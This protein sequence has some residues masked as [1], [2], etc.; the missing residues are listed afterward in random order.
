[1]VYSYSYLMFNRK[2]FASMLFIALLEHTDKMVRCVCTVQY[3]NIKKI[4]SKQRLTT[5]NF[6][7][8]FNLFY[9]STLKTLLTIKIEAELKRNKG[10]TLFR[11]YY[12]FLTV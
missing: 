10:E 6:F 8:N 1:M 3:L 5:T 9:I 4:L 11:R 7:L 12:Y 2:D